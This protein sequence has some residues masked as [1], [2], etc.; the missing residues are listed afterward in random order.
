MMYPLV[1][2]I[3]SLTF[4]ILPLYTAYDFYIIVYNQYNSFIKLLLAIP[5]LL[6]VLLTFCFI[7]LIAHN[8]NLGLTHNIVCLCK[9]TLDILLNIF[10]LYIAATCTIN[11]NQLTG[12]ISIL[13]C[14]IIIMLIDLVTIVYLIY[15]H[16]NKH[17]KHILFD[18][19]EYII[20]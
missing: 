8:T 20:V 10:L 17:K 19:Q 11:N 9:C 2:C 7:V 16:M 18:E 4:L 15:Y 3:I 13:C 6:N 5:A 14:T 12:I 1:L